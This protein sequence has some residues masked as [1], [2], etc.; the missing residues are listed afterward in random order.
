[1]PRS[2][3]PCF[4]LR[5]VLFLQVSS[6]FLALRSSWVRPVLTCSSQSAGSPGSRLRYL[7][8]VACTCSCSSSRQ[9]GRV[10][11]FNT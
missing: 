1:M 2:S 9:Q 5:G 8:N 10:G 6:I 11:V 7:S 4:L 3:K